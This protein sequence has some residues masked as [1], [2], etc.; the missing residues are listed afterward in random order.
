MK[1]AYEQGTGR[2]LG[3][4][5]KVAT[6]YSGAPAGLNDPSRQDEPDVGP[7]PCGTWT[8]GAPYFSQSHGPYVLPLTPQPGTQ[9]FGRG[10]FLIHGD[11]LEH[12]GEASKGCIILPLAVRQQIWREGDHQIEV[13]EGL[14]VVR[15]VAC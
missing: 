11:S 15:E 8:I 6:G 3:D 9:T 2:L 7:I 5:I 13:V 4:G 10:G 12:P 1:F 14:S